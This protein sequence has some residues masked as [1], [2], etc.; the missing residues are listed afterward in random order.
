MVNTE[1]LRAMA[2]KLRSDAQERLRPRDVHTAK[3]LAQARTAER[4]GEHFKRAA[5]LIDGYI[6]AVENGVLPPDLAQYKPTKQSFLEASA[7]ESKNV[8]NGYHGYLVD[9]GEYR[10]K[11]PDAAMLRAIAEIVEGDAAIARQEANAQRQELTLALDSIRNCDI[12][13]FFPTP[14][15]VVSLMLEIADLENSHRILEPSAGIGSIVEEVRKSGFV[16]HID[17]LEINP[18]LCRILELKGISAKCADFL[19]C[20][21]GEYDRILMNPPFEKRQAIKHV[22]HAFSLL[23]DGGMVI[24][25]MPAPHAKELNFGSIAE[26]PVAANAFNTSEAFCKTSVNV[27]IVQVCKAVAYC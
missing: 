1:K 26:Y 16:G 21:D 15:S 4:D 9:S 14:P 24:A 3:K 2:D 6:Y 22:Q 25:I 18:T 10:S 23:N 13:G 7:M 11:S 27:A 19:A 12:P 17:A 20:S 8:S 5:I